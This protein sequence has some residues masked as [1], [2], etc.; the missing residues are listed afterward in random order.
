M[1]KGLKK[2]HIDSVGTGGP[3][4]TGYLPCKNPKTSSANKK[5]RVSNLDFVK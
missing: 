4:T 1:L 5:K 2:N 3:V